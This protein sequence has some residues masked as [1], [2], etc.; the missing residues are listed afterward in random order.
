MRILITGGGTGGHINPALAIGG[1]VKKLHPSWEVVYAGD[2]TKMEG[3][4]IPAAGFKLYPISMS[5]LSRGWTLSGLK[6]NLKT[7]KASVAALKAA[8]KILAEFRPDL[9][10]GVGGFVSWPLVRQAQRRKIRTMIHEQNT[11]PGVTTKLLAK[12]ADVVLLPNAKAGE[13]IR[14]RKRPLSSAIP[15]A[16]S[17][18]TATVP[19]RVKRRAWAR[20]NY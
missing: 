15:C 5:G 7:L 3:R 16:T 14:A 10:I 18:Y 9:V 2:P 17:S 6:Y 1:F 13:R 12:R 20:M 11:F 19:P 8:D 4:L